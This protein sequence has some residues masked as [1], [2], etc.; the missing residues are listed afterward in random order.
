[1]AAPTIKSLLKIPLRLNVQKDAHNK[2]LQIVEMAQATVKDE[3]EFQRTSAKER[4]QGRALPPQVLGRYYARYCDLINKMYDAYLNSIHLQRSPYIL[5]II[6]LLMKRMYELRN[7]LVHVLVNDYIYVDAA[8]QQLRMTPFDIEIVLPYHFPLESRE[9]DMESLL[10][11]MWAAAIKRKKRKGEE[12]NSLLPIPKEPKTISQ[13]GTLLSQVNLPAKEDV[14]EEETPEP[15][16]HTIENKDLINATIIQ[17]HERYRQWFAEQFRANC[18][19]RRTYFATVVVE[20]SP[21]LKYKAAKLIQ[22]VYREYMK[23]KRKRIMDTK[24]NILLGLVPDPCP[25]RLDFHEENN[26]IYQKRR[27]TRLKI[28]KTFL[29]EEERENA[30]LILFKKDNQI[31]DITDQV[32]EWFKEWY[33]GYGFFPEYP[34]ELEGGTILVI[35]G[36]YITIEEKQKEDA[37]QS[38]QPKDK[39]QIKAEKARA[40]QEAKIKAEQARIA[41]QKEALDEYKA[42]MNPLTDPGY[43]VERS[44][45]VPELVNVMREYRSAWSIYDML[46]S[47]E[48]G[49]TIYGYMKP[50]L[51][52]ALMSQLHI[53]CRKYVDELM[54]LDL[55]LLIE[56]HQKLYKSIG[57]KFPKIKPRPKPKKIPVS[58]P[59]IVDQKLL[60]N[61]EE[62]FDLGIISKPTAKL[63]DVFGDMNYAAYDY[64]IRDPDPKFPPPGYADFKQ[65]VM[66]SCILGCG[67]QPGATK[68]NGVMLLGPVGNGKSFLV[69]VVAGELNAVKIDITPEV[70]SAV[71]ARPAKA[72]AQVFLAARVFQPAVIYM[73]NIERVFAKKVLPEDKYLKAATLKPILVKM[74]KQISEKDKIIFIATC[75]NPFE[76]NRG[77]MLSCFNEVIL[78]PRT[79]YGSLFKFFY[80]KFQREISVP[81]DFPISSLA[82]L[83]RGYGFGSIIKAYNQVM[84][85]ER[86]VSMNV[87]PLSPGEFLDKVFDA[88]VLLDDDDYQQYVNFYLDNSPIK[89]EREEYNVINMYRAEHYKKMAKLEME[90]KKKKG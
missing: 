53:D 39:E 52:E 26:K 64:N 7:E 55:K 9:E 78:V 16:V 24:R 74:V 86:I 2:W 32:R 66:L 20:P 17:K 19:R 8:L 25:G 11:K 14:V 82:Q 21:E 67:I 41:K 90:A 61:I 29:I 40:K 88:G 62:I 38:K 5:E 12:V 28:Q 68:N 22:R 72:L 89:K 33:Y 50:L 13:H 80:Y 69:D 77:P 36:Q 79:D 37:I 54:R 60:N 31:S 65:R 51:T 46:P 57:K 87:T 75:S 27:E 10:Q 34:Y 3:D 44:E 1:M 73:R 23:I 84:C 70:F 45:V 71:S 76:A 81:R 56:A 43:R 35:R 58:K 4:L 15:S 83:C 47:A 18:I 48:C 85:A 49:E 63:S 59:L 30:R 42:K 6:S